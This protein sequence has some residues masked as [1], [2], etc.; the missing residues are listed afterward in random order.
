MSLI[1]AAQQP[2]G[3]TMTT[4]RDFQGYK[5]TAEQEQASQER[6]Q[7]TFDLDIAFHGAIP[8]YFNAVDIPLSMSKDR[9]LS[10]VVSHVT[11]LA[12]LGAS[13]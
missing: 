6:G 7:A 8:R 12:I 13:A 5:L 9:G 3:D 4:I 11:A 10:W 2:Q 1:S